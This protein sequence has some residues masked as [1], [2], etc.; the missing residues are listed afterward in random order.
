MG[1]GRDGGLRAGGL[2]G[3]QGDS[4]GLAQNT[5]A[6]QPGGDLWARVP[7]QNGVNSAASDFPGATV[8]G[9]LPADAGDT[10]LIPAP[11]GSHV[12]R[13]D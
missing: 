9:T 12:P 2:Q 10:G 13:S 8:N 6:T 4:Q 3:Q 5:P 7:S 11:G 1:R